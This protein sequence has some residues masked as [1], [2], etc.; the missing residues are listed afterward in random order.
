MRALP[1]LVTIIAWRS[2][3]HTAPVFEGDTLGTELT[4]E[5]AHPMDGGHG[6]LDLRCV[7]RAERGADA[8]RAGMEAGTEKDVLDWRFVALM[9]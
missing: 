1:N 5:D 9:A 2:C 7:T 6:L 8:V 3:E 4:V